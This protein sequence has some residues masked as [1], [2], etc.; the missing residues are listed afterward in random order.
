MLGDGHGDTHDVC[1][2]ESVRANQFGSDLAGNEDYGFGIHIGIGN[3]GYQVGGAGARRC[4]GNAGFAGGQVVTL[5]CVACTLFVTHQDVA[6][7]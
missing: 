6:D 3:G 1:F 7:P 4:N 2:L 5:R